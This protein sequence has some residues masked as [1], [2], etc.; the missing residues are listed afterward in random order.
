MTDFF[1]YSDSKSKEHPKG[2]ENDK[3]R[4]PRPQEPRL[5]KFVQVSKDFFNII[6][7]ILIST[8]NRLFSDLLKNILCSHCRLQ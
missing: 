7:Y 8:F 2:R 1:V 5:S 6:I 4:G 3:R